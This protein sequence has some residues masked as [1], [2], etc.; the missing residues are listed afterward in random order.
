[1]TFDQFLDL[2]LTVIEHNP[3]LPGRTLM[4]MLSVYYPSLYAVLNNSNL[5]TSMTGSIETP[6]FTAACK[7]LSENWST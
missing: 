1:M 3:E 4:E 6:V 5:D 7:W 2:V